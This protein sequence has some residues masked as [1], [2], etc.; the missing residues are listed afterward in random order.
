MIELLER[1]LGDFAVVI[2]WNLLLRR[3][4]SHAFGRGIIMELLES[5][6]SPRR[7]IG[8]EIRSFK[9]N[10]SDYSNQMRSLATL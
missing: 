7:T 1:R 2:L 8:S 9:G 5:Q 4:T 10:E 3:C 6:S